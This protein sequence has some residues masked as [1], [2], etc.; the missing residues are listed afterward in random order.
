MPGY[1]TQRRPRPILG[2]IYCSTCRDGP[3]DLCYESNTA[4]HHLCAFCYD[5]ILENTYCCL[6]GYRPRCLVH[7]ST[8]TDHRLYGPYLKKMGNGERALL[9]ILIK[10]HD[11][12]T[13]LGQKF[14]PPDTSSKLGQLP[15]L[16]WKSDTGA[17]MEAMNSSC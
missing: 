13:S 10:D 8:T 17:I 12:S 9:R 4:D 5:A 1:Y 14:T 6:C 16:V 2:L 15:V 7:Q 3:L 11:R